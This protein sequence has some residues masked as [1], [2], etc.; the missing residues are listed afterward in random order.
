ML[1]NL[2]LSAGEQGLHDH[3]PKPG[4][5]RSGGGVAVCSQL[6]E[7]P[8]A[9]CACASGPEDTVLIEGH[10]GCAAILSASTGM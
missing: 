10:T 3:D 7:D 4:A 6:P 2:R 5:A 9:T 8:Q 1:V